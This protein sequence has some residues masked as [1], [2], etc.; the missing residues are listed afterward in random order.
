MFYHV[1][2]AGYQHARARER[3]W[4]KSRSGEKVGKKEREEEERQR[5]E[6]RRE[7][8]RERERNSFS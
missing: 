7:T 6:E 5:E 2:L 4:A 8:R 3:G 1:N